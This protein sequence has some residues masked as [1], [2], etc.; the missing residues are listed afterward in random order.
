MCVNLGIEVEL[1]MENEFNKFRFW[2]IFVN[3][4]FLGLCGI[5][6]NYFLKKYFYCYCYNSDLGGFYLYAGLNNE[7]LELGIVVFCE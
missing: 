2:G 1:Y 4:S 7:I 6:S 5:R 3:I